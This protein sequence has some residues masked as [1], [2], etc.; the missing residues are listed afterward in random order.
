ML[1]KPGLIVLYLSAGYFN[2]EIAQCFR[3]IILK[4][5]KVITEGSK[6]WIEYLSSSREGIKLGYAYVKVKSID[7]RRTVG[8]TRHLKWEGKGMPGGEIQ[9]YSRERQIRNIFQLS[10]PTKLELLLKDQPHL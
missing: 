3:P 8:E 5:L 10:N 6:V 4:D 2:K 1:I 9:V 7:R